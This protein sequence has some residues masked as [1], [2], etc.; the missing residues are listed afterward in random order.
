MSGA[1][2]RLDHLAVI[3]PDLGA[4]A[5]AYERMGFQLTPYARHAGSPTPGAPPVPMGTANRCAMFGSGYLELIGVEDPRLPTHGMHELSLRYPGAHIVAFGCPDAAA[6]QRRLEA[7]GFAGLAV[8]LLQREVDGPQ[9]R[10][11]ARFNLIRVPEAVM[12]EGGL[13]VIDHQTPEL[14]WQPPFLSHPN[15]ARALEEFLLCVRDL[16]EAAERF[17][18]FLGLA[19]A[20]EGPRRV[21]RLPHGRVAL[22]RPEDVPGE[23]PG[24]RAPAVPSVVAVT[25]TTAAPEQ[26]RALLTRNGV[27]FAEADGRLVVPAGQAHG[28]VCRFEPA[29]R[30]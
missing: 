14:L 9:G 4:L 29:N 24:H 10:A 28:V 3:G 8:N 1:I 7:A 15:G 6:E 11:L 16:G 13:R 27:P 12:A 20:A 22:I 25:F 19:P 18:R 21:F 17:G 5:A 23:L 26:A 2:E 30:R